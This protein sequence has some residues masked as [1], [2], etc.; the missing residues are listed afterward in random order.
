[1]NLIA[2]LLSLIAINFVGNAEA[3]DRIALIIGNE[4]YQYIGGLNNPISDTN[5]I[6]ESLSN[7]GFHVEKFAN[8]GVKSFSKRIDEFVEK[9]KSY[10]ENNEIEYEVVLFY[11]AG[12]A[13]QE[14]GGNFLLPVDIMGS[15]K[16]VVESGIPISDLV[17]RISLIQS[18]GYIYIF[19]ACRNNPFEQSAGARNGLAEFDAPLNSYIAFAANPGG[20]AFDGSN[21]SPYSYN[22]AYYLN[23]KSINVEDL[24]RRVRKAVVKDTDGAQVPWETSSLTKELILNPSYDGG[25]LATRES[26]LQKDASLWRRILNSGS[27]K[28]AL[29]AYLLLFPNGLYSEEA[30]N[31]LDSH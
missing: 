22:L 6:E 23:Y 13:V 30:R 7:S 20:V 26:Y 29:E 10:K 19:D 11:F 27:G 16:D 25:E 9:F 12:H 21:N 4:D 18:G 8:L 2:V 28:G 5:L 3:A 31:A 1:M 15:R 17:S 24:F 14:I